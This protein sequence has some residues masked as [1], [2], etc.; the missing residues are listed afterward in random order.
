MVNISK[1]HIEPFV[2]R[3]SHLGKKE[4][5]QLSSI[6]SGCLKAG[7]IRISNIAANMP[8]SVEGN[9]KA[10]QRF[11]NRIGIEDIELILWRA[12]PGEFDFVIIDPTEIE[13]PEAEKTEYVGRLK[14][15][16]TKGYS[17]LMVS[18]PYKGRAIP[19][20]YTTYSSKTIDKEVSSRNA[21]QMRL[22]IG[23]KEMIGNAVV[24]ADREFSGE[25]FFEGLQ[26]EGMKYAVRLKDLRAIRQGK[27]KRAEAVDLTIL[28]GQKKLWTD[29]YYKGNLL[30]NVVGY[31]DSRFKKPMYIITNMDGA[32]GLQIYRQRMKIEESFRDM[33]DI[34]GID[35]NMSKKEDMM[36]KLIGMTLLAYVIAFFSRGNVKRTMYQK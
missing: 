14:D 12:A 27:G 8:G 3:I 34:L 23:L 16:K 21:E 25:W 1:Q 22:I 4:N 26:Q 7:K 18:V 5:E 10:M 17:V 33:K 29:V 13:R 9:Y 15:G 36:R 35:K 32:L 28:P 20:G 2:D 19:I 31:W 30:A 11:S 24:I 6:L